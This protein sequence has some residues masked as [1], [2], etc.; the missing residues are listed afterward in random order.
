[1]LDLM[2]YSNKTNNLFTPKT[3]EWI[4]IPTLWVSPL[5]FGVVCHKLATILQRPTQLDLKINILFPLQERH[6]KTYNT[7][8]QKLVQ[9][10][11]CISIYINC[12]ITY[13]SSKIASRF[14][15]DQYIT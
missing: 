12:K 10:I 1:M 4:I 15:E 13:P 9:S 2:F 5:S 3:S 7:S 8:V 14:F 11:V 6:Q